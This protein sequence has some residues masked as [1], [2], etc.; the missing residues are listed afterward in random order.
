MLLLML[1]VA[2]RSGLFSP[3]QVLVFSAGMTGSL[4]V[5]NGFVQGIGRRTAIYLSMRKPRMA[6]RYLTVATIASTAV[7]VTASAV[8]VAWLILYRQN[9]ARQLMTFFVSFV[10]FT[11]IW[12]SAGGLS[13]VE[14]AHWLSIGLAIGMLVGTIATFLAYTYT[15]LPPAFGILAGYLFAV[16]IIVVALNRRYVKTDGDHSSSADYHFPSLS[17]VLLEGLPY[18]AYG[19]LYMTLIM[20]PHFLAWRGSLHAGQNASWRVTSTEIGLTFSMP[21]IILAYSVAEYAMRLF[22]RVGAVAQAD[23]AG[24]KIPGFGQILLQFAARKRTL[25]M[26]TLGALSL[27]TYFFF[28]AAVEGGLLARWLHIGDTVSASFHLRCPAWSPMRY[29]VLAC[30]TACLP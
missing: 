28:H 16:L 5:T 8:V 29:S 20:M 13:L 7:I 30:T 12:M 25:Y 23:V 27:V 11:V 18:F 1:L 26:T 15:Q 24:S 19:A 6:A 2:S 14:G 9:D 22:W 17:Y 10:G 3:G 4:L 21:P